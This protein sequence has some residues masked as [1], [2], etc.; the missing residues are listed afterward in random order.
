MSLKKTGRSYLR[1]TQPDVWKIAYDVSSV[2]AAELADKKWRE[3]A[4]IVDGFISDLIV[5]MMGADG[6]QDLAARPIAEL[7]PED[8]ASSEEVAQIVASAR[9]ILTAALLDLPEGDPVIKDEI[10]SP[11]QALILLLSELPEHQ[12]AARDWSAMK[13]VENV[14]EILRPLAGITTLLLADRSA[15]NSIEA[16]TSFE[17]LKL[18]LDEFWGDEATVH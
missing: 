2:L 16:I 12:G 5:E 14:V 17:K 18:I 6:L 7:L 4:F 9:A 1:D 13:G 10:T 15:K 3:R 11:D 8:D